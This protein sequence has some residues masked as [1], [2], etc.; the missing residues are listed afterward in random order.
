MTLPLP[1]DKARFVETMFDAVAPRY[2]LMNRLM[3]F[4]IDR[5][6][7]KATVAALGLSAGDLVVDLG[8]GT[9]GLCVEAVGYGASPVGVDFSSAM[10]RLAARQLPATALLRADAGRLPLADASA[11]AVMSGFALRN[12]DRVTEV[13]DECGRILRAGGRLAFL[14]VDVPANRLIKT[15]FD[16]YF[17]HVM[18]LLGRMVSRGYAYHYLSESIVYLPTSEQL[19]DGLEAAG[20]VDIRKR[21]FCL[22]SAQLVT[23]VRGDCGGAVAGES[24]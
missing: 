3:T 23:A 18:P 12:F 9:G 17:H 7:R 22:G 21:C 20:F 8:C 5:G 4:G 10:L 11:D 19:R 2:D 1:A 14:E 24:R 15:G 16:F 13:L 6:W